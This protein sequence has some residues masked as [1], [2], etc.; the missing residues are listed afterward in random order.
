MNCYIPN[1]RHKRHN[2][3]RAKVLTGCRE[4]FSKGAGV[5]WTPLPK[6]EA[7]TEPAGETCPAGKMTAVIEGGALTARDILR[8]PGANIRSGIPPR[9][10]HDPG[11]P[12]KVVRLFGVGVT[13]LQL[14]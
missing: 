3:H 10:A 9:R 13:S 7:P 5:R 6:A 14:C 8:P 2:R 4:T 1:N 12:G 11:V